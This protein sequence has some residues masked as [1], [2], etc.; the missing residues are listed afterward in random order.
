MTAP[1]S[2]ELA[3]RE[4]KASTRLT[5]GRQL[6]LFAAALVLYVVSLALPQAGSVRGWE[7][8][9][10]MP[11]AEEAGIKITEY[12]FATLVALGVGVLTTLVLI[13][14]RTGL[15]IIAW[16]ISTVGLAYSVL[17][18]WLRQT[19]SSSGDGV[20]M[21]PGFWLALLAVLLAF[22][23]YASV[24]LRRNPEQQEL[25]RERASAENLDEVG[26]LQQEA[27]VA[28]EDNP[29]LIDDRRSRAS[30][31]H[32]SRTTRRPETPQ[33]GQ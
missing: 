30:Q 24:V 22:L 8:L 15:A 16:M 7:V 27:A 2:S 9:L 6:W 4:K 19:R 3:A 5:L 13:T 12:V 17:A 1:T 23:G 11:A 32:R 20:E 21:G 18:M 14:R 29:L 33:D 28:P 31:R 10:H 25:A 26:R